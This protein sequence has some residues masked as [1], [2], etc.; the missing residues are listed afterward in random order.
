MKGRTK[1]LAALALVVVAFGVSAYYYPQFPERMT[2]HWNAS[3]DADGTTPKVWGA[4]F[5]PALAAGLLCLF[6]VIPKIDPLGENVEAFREHYDLFVVLLV[7]FV[8]YVHLLVVL[9]N[10]DY[11]F[12]FTAVLAPAIGALY[13]FVGTLMNRVER[14]WF[15]GV[16]TPWTMTSD[17]VWRK[18][19]S[20]AGPLFKLAGVVAL[21]GALVPAYAVYLIAGPAVVVALY[22]AV[23]SYVEYRRVSA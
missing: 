13:Y 9:W 19:H 14:N 12:E 23:Y 10:L 2:T 1:Y 22:L 8:L 17:E 20:R 7:A 11:R 6:A 15:V 5:L 3:G 18:T 4:F 21:L 16:R